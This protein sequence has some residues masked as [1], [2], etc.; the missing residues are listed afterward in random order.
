VEPG[1]PHQR[2]GRFID[3][4]ILKKGTWV[5]VAAQATPVQR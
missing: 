2:E 1:K 4:W 5:C 3:I